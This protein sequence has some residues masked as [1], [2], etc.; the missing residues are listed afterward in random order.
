MY[1]L[2]P[3]SIEPFTPNKTKEKFTHNK[4]YKRV[5]FSNKNE[6]FE[7]KEK[8][9]NINDEDED[10]DNFQNNLKEKYNK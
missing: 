7:N 10:E 1:N 3:A 5:G 4:T 8:L 9:K 2:N 6:N